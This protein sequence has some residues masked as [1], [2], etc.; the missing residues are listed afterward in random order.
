MLLSICAYL[1]WNNQNDVGTDNILMLQNIE[2]LANGEDSDPGSKTCYT[3]VSEVSSDDFLAVQ[4]RY[5]WTC[6]L[7]WCTSCSSRALC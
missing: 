7:K 5:C 6:S 1:G 3:S 2:A 4:V